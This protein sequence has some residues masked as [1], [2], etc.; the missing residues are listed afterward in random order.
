MTLQPLLTLAE[1][2]EELADSEQ[3]LARVQSATR[4]VDQEQ[5]RDHQI[6]VMRWILRL[7]QQVRELEAA[8]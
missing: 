7:R 5:H 1:A 8:A 6:R 4:V 2:R 3:T